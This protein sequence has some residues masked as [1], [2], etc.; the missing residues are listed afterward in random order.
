M[1][2]LLWNNFP[3]AIWEYRW[4][5]QQFYKTAIGLFDGGSSIEDVSY[6]QPPPL[7]GLVAQNN[8]TRKHYL[9]ILHHG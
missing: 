2:G 8:E 1:Y 7:E 9:N 4:G 3:A 5:D 6:V